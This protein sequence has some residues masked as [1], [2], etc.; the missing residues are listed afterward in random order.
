[1]Q[2][3]F[4]KPGIIPRTQY[5]QQLSHGGGGQLVVHSWKGDRLLSM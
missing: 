2:R 1:M 4:G 5:C 3:D